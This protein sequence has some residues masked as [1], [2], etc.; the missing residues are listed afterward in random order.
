MPSDPNI[1]KTAEI[2]R[3]LARLNPGDGIYFRCSGEQPFNRIF[4]QR[5]NGAAYVLW[6]RGAYKMIA[7]KGEVGVMRRVAP[8]QERAA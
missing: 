4:Y 8:A 3:S 7:G 1:T 5:V 2:K 6:G